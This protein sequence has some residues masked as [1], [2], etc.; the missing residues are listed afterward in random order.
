MR[1]LNPPTCTCKAEPNNTSNVASFIIPIIGTVEI[2][3]FLA[4]GSISGSNHPLK[5]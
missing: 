3:G 2:L 1:Q 5:K 4:I